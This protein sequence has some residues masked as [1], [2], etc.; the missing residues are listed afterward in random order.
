MPSTGI[1]DPVAVAVALG[2]TLGAHLAVAGAGQSPDVPSA[3]AR[4]AGPRASIEETSRIESRRGIQSRNGVDR[5]AIAL[6][7][8]KRRL[9]M[10]S[11]TGSAI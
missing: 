1:P 4:Q 8:G 6:T 7:A 9:G 2:R 11:H 10:P 5:A 3:A